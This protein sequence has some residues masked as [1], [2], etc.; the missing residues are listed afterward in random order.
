MKITDEH[1]AAF[2]EAFWQVNAASKIAANSDEIRRGLEAAFA[3]RAKYTREQIS[4]MIGRGEAF[5]ETSPEADFIKHS[6]MSCPHCGGS[7]HKDDVRPISSSLAGVVEPLEEYERQEA[8]CTDAAM[9]QWERSLKRPDMQEKDRV[10]GA[11][12]AYK[13]QALAF[14][15]L[16]PAPEKHLTVAD[17][18]TLKACDDW[19]ATF[20]VIAIKR[21]PPSAESYRSAQ[22]HIDALLE[23]G[24]LEFGRPNTTYRITAA[25]RAA[26]ATEG[27]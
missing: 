12:E 1:I 2:G 11:V 21:L 20:E 8:I 18:E 4:E 7:G 23:R 26:L 25:G 6:E 3:V 15:I 19:K 5:S 13:R 16:P 14:R 22:Q 24:L 10:R 17:I 27:K 9:S